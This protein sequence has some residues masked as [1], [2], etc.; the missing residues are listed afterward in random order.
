M[1][2]GEPTGL[3]G[4]SRGAALGTG[5]GARDLC[6]PVSLDPQTRPERLCMTAVGSSPKPGLS[7]RSAALTLML[8]RT[9][10][11]C[12]RGVHITGTVEHAVVNVQRLRWNTG[13]RGAGDAS[14]DHLLIFQVTWLSRRRLRVAPLGVP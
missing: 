12:P 6:V 11:V 1:P 2:W 9:W 7:L 14:V 8:A 4:A 3:E 5:P 10:G 13:P